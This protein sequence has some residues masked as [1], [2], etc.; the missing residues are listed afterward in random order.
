TTQLPARFHHSPRVHDPAPLH[1]PLEATTPP[2]AS[3]SVRDAVACVGA[4]R[5]RGPLT[6][7]TQQ[8]PQG[9]LLP[10]SAP[11]QHADGHG[12]GDEHDEGDGPEPPDQHVEGA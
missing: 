10:G 6:D 8:Y 7:H 5:L 12:V 4:P 1:T 2:D 11:P 3:C 9:G